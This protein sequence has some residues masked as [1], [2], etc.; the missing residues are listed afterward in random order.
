MNWAMGGPP[1]KVYGMGG[2]QVRTDPAYGHIF[3]HFAIEYEFANG[4][5]WTGQCRQIDGTASRVSEDILG[6]KGSAW[7]GGIRGD[8][9]W[10][11]EGDERNPYEQEH[12]DMIAGIQAGKPLNE[13]KRIAESTLTAIMARESA[14]TGQEITWDE[15]MKS[16]LSLAPAPLD[17]LTLDMKLPVPAV[18]QPGKTKLDRKEFGV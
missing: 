13:A 14:Y 2:R 4:A 9:P 3:D 17:T 1:V 8:K 12:V 6:T 16:P 10:R 15:I 11:F 5:R 18:A 7:T